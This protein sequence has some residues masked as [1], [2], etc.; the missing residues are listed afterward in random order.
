MVLLEVL[1]LHIEAS[2]R[3]VLLE[4]VRVLAPEFEPLD[5]LQIVEVFA[6]L[7]LHD[8][9]VRLV[10]LHEEVGIV[11]ADVAVGILIIEREVEAEVVAPVGHDII[12]VL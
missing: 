4:R 11:L 10:L 5:L 7:R 12:A 3:H 6:S 2:V 1:L 9:Y 8:E